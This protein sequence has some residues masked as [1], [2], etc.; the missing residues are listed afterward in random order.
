[1][2]SFYEYLDVRRDAS[3]MEIRLAYRRRVNEVHPDHG[4][5]AIEFLNVQK[6]YSILSDPSKRLRYDRWLMLQEHQERQTESKKT[7]NKTKNSTRY[8]RKRSR[9]VF[10][11]IISLAIFI[12]L[13]VTMVAKSCTE[14]HKVEYIISDDNKPTTAVTH[15]DEELYEDEE[16]NVNASTYDNSVKSFSSDKPD[17]SIPKANESPSYIVTHFKTGD[18]PY[19]DYFGRGIFDEESLSFL[20]VIN[21]S[22]TDAVVLLVASSGQVLRNV[23]IQ[24]GSQYEMNMIPASTCVIRVLH[25]VEWN[26]Q[27]NNGPNAPSGGFMRNIGITE[28]LWKD[29][30]CFTPTERSDG[31]EYPTYSVTLHKVANG[32][33]RNVDIS[34][35][36]FF[37][38]E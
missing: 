37:D 26:K 14:S 22:E 24:K 13:F 34:L 15:K 36:H 12:V 31:I 17:V 19:G 38:K 7:C 18:I 4:G 23:Y 16:I 2:K 25:G 9:G 35:E 10:V 33:F 29:P 27:K 6:G 5:D 30:F 21:Y 11:Y 3:D 1:M 8:S 20:R 28:S 32:N